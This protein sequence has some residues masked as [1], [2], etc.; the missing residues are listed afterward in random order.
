MGSQRKSGYRAV[1]GSKE[2]ETNVGSPRRTLCVTG[3]RE[4]LGAS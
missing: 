2:L 1:D 3:K 4:I